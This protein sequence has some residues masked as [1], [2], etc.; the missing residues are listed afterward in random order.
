MPDDVNLLIC[1]CR[2]ASGNPQ[3]IFRL[4]YDYSYALQHHDHYTVDR[5]EFSDLTASYMYRLY[6]TKKNR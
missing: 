2:S 4:Q 3:T 5:V 6:D 1:R